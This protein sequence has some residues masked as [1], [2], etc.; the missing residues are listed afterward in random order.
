MRTDPLTWWQ[1]D[2]LKIDAQSLDEIESNTSKEDTLYET[3]PSSTQESEPTPSERHGFLF[4]HNLYP[5][6]PDI[7]DLHPFPLQIPFLLVGFSENV[8]FIAQ[9]VYMPAINKMVRDL[10]VNGM[11]NVTPAN[12]ALLFSM[13]YAAIASMENDDVGAP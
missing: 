3:T 2:G 5:A 13:Y 7:R 8:N 11:A 10:R 12:E 1:L 4:R 9:I 6:S